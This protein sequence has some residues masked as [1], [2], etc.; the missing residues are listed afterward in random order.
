MTTEPV[1]HLGC[2]F[3]DDRCLSFPVILVIACENDV[4]QDLNL[5]TYLLSCKLTN[6]DTN[7][8]INTGD[9]KQYLARAM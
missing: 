3:H 4:F 8:V 1:V 9:Q 5:L 6:M 2:K 7:K